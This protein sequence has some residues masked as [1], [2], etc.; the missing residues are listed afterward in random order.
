QQQEGINV[1]QQSGQHLLTLIN[2]ILDLSK[3]EARKM[4][5]YA[6]AFHLPNFLESLAGIIGMRAQE[7]DTTFIYEHNPDLPSGVEADEKRL[8][9]VLINLLGNAIKFTDQGSVTL[10]VSVLS[11]IPV[12]PME[13]RFEVID[14]GVG[15]TAEQLEKIF[16]PFEQVGDIERRSAGTGLGLA[17]S[18]QLVELMGSKLQVSSEFNQGSTFWFDLSVPI[19]TAEAELKTTKTGNII[20]YKGERLKVL[21]VDDK[22]EN[23]AVLHGMLEP[24]GFEIIEGINGKEEIEKAQAMKPN[25]ILTD[26]VMPVMT[27]FEAVQEIRKIPEIQDIVIIA[28][29]ASVF[30]VDQEK[31]RIGGF[32]NFLP[33]P[34][35]ADKLFNLIANHLNLEWTYEENNTIETV[36][37]VTGEMIPPS[38]EELEILFELAMDGDMRGIRKRASF[39]EQ[40]TE[41]LI[42]F[43]QKL[44][45]LAKGFKDEQILD[46]ITRFKKAGE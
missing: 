1:I 17:I 9:Q 21:V 12:T 46:F 33:K 13:I 28:V 4:E 37:K 31:C 6:S 32:N 45:T 27:G 44:Q 29:S 25:I 3:I 15:M 35:E 10:K 42:P 39:M 11:K 38:P 23:R 5:L 18:L 24:L 36:G 20:G 19:V 8:R 26:L 41:E 43:V 30:D 40:S 16:L 22:R 2:D 7:K 14:T 34:I